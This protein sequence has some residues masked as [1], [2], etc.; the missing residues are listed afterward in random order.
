MLMNEMTGFFSDLPEV[1][2]P[3]YKGCDL[4]QKSS[5]ANSAQDSCNL[6]CCRL[7]YH[8]RKINIRLDGL[9]YKMTS[10][11]ARKKPEVNKMILAKGCGCT[12]IN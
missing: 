8:K 3:R 1:I 10:F 12:R 11:M 4:G 7:P 2:D 5:G 9:G 6:R